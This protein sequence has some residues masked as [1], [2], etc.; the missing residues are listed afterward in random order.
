MAVTICYR[1]FDGA[2]LQVDEV[3]A[4]QPLRYIDGYAQVVFGLAEGLRGARAGD[5]RTIEVPPEQAFGARDAS[6]LLEID[7]GDIPDAGAIKVG[8]EL[9]AVGP[10]GDEVSYRVAEIRDDTIMA[11]LNH[12]LAGQRV[13]FDVTV[14]S[15][16]PASDD[17]LDA[18]YAEINERIA[19]DATIVYGSG[20]DTVAATAAAAS[21]EQASGLVQ[22]RHGA[23]HNH[24]S[25][26]REKP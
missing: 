16:R 24:P 12:P 3:S 2:G 18:A 6:A 1:L 4:D 25:T 9:L 22:L 17:E 23:S 10:N 15:V 21:A 19:H 26:N 20:P 14:L 8:D 11:D 7:P 5:M 13:R